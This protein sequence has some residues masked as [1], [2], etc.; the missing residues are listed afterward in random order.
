MNLQ[1]YN[2]FGYTKFANFFTKEKLA[3]Y[4]TVIDRLQKELPISD[5]VF[6]ENK[7]GKI[8]QI[9]YL[10]NKDDIFQ[11]MLEELRPLGAKILGHDKFTILNMQL[12][13]KH[14]YI[15][16]PTRSHQD[17]AYFQL[18]PTTPMTIWVALDDID[19]EN[20]CLYYAPT[21]HK[22]PTHKH[23]RYHKLTTFRIRSGVPGLSL[24]L[25]EHPEETDVPLPVN[26]GDVLMHNCNT[27]HRAGK[28][29]SERR[30]RAIGIVFIP[31]E[32]K[33]D[34]RLVKYHTDRLTE[35]IELQKIKDPSLYDSLT[36]D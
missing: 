5:E 22:R 1:E 31:D 33:K 19:E 17:N 28:N 12:F 3:N 18:T 32:C 30:R 27:I 26:A 13:E 15:S 14:P 35:D 21:S 20:G 2:Q 24:C 11:E 34:P 7:T 4:N 10:Y 16:K 9:Q 25:H 6:E 8:K 23:S 29:N 36:K